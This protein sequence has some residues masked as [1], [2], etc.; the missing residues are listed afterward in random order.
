MSFI[1]IMKMEDINPNLEKIWEEMKM[2][3]DVYKRQEWG[4]FM[5]YK[6]NIADVLVKARK[7]MQMSQDTLAKKMFVTRQAVSNLSLIHICVYLVDLLSRV[8]I[9][10]MLQEEY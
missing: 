10:K 1:P 6:D 3:K 4:K 2:V 8:K 5:N 9:L 7:R